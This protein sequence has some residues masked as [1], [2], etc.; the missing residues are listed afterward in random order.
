MQVQHGFAPP[1][2]P[3]FVQ[4]FNVHDYRAD[5]LTVGNAKRTKPNGYTRVQ[6]AVDLRISQAIP[7]GHQI[8]FEVLLALLEGGAGEPL[9]VS[10]SI[11]LTSD[12]PTDRWLRYKRAFKN[13][14]SRESSLL[15]LLIRR[16]EL[17]NPAPLVEL[18]RDRTEISYRR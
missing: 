9:I 2:S 13:L 18:W 15:V 11:R 3:G 17:S 6:V 8:E 12:M 4:R 16:N 7:L 10:Q 1:M 14:P 5:A